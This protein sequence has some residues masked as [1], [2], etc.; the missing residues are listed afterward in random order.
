MKKLTRVEE[1]VMQHIWD[2][3]SCTV[4]QIIDRLEGPKPPHS[5][6]SSIARI[7]EKKGFLMHDAYGRTHVYKPLIKREVYKKNSLKS[8]VSNYFDGSVENLVS[9]LVREKEI[10]LADLQELINEE[11]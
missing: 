1:D 10:G 8:L 3:K 5:T 4:S 11:E 7:L 6:I 2:L 9:F